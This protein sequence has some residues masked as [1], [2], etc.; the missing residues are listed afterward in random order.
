MAKAQIGRLIEAL[1]PRALLAA[2]YYV[3]TTGNNASAGSSGAPWRTLQYAA[4][5]VG[6]GDTVIVAPGNYVGFNLETSGTPSARITFKAQ[7]GAVINAVNGVTKDGINLENASYVTIDGFTLSG[8]NDPATSRAGIR[9]VGDGFDTGV[10]SKGVII[11]NNTADRWGVWGI[12]TAFADD[13]TIQNNVC[14]RS[15]QQHGIY[16]SNSADRPTIRNNVCWGNADC[17]IHVNADINTGNTDLP[18][19][20]GVITGALIDGNTCYDN[21]R[22]GGSAINCDG[23][24]NSRITNN[25]LYNNHASGISLFD[26]D[27]AQP[28]KNNVVANNTIIQAADGRWCLN[29]SDGSTG[30][31]IFNNIFFNLHSF[32]GSISIDAAS[33]AGTVSDYNLLDPRFS[34][35]DTSE[36]L[37]QW[38]ADLGGI[39]ESHSKTL[40]LAQMQALFTSYAASDFTLAASSA[41]ID[42]GTSGVTN[43]TLKAA[44]TIDRLKHARPAGA[45][46]DIGAY[47]ALAANFATVVNG[48]LTVLGTTSG[49]SIAF[50]QSGSTFTITRNGATQNISTAGVTSIEIYGDDGDDSITIGTGVTAV[51]INAGAGNDLIHGGEQN[52]TISGGAGKDQI[53]GGAGDDLLNG[54]TSADRLFGDAGNDRLHG[55]D[56]NDYLVG[57]SGSDRIWGEAGNNLFYGQDGDDYFYARN[58]AAD[59]LNGGSGTNHA[60]VDPGT[61]DVRTLVQDLLA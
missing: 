3:A 11:Q 50:T 27:G 26:I 4:D 7:K 59:T 58:S 8:T 45:G 53:Y 17:G 60:Q 56:G 39:T 29:I 57:G 15:V 51:Y 41:A 14:S 25:L 48:K 49:D 54:N 52:D 21:G 43:G 35:D 28:S 55:N 30:T 6:A 1:E 18:N 10:F 46:Y 33:K 42:S 36:T 31:T 61:T 12:F 44:P 13:I 40:T 32:R 22:T 37:A 2:T 47:E 20:D 38:K 23:V 5:H 9:A 34:D 19:V 24:Q 16:F